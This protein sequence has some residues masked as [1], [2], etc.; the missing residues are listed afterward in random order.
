MANFKPTGRGLEKNFRYPTFIASKF[1]IVVMKTLTL[2]TFSSLLPPASRTAE[3]FARAC[4]W[5]GVT[6]GCWSRENNEG[7]KG[8]IE[9]QPKFDDNDEGGLAE[10]KKVKP[11]VLSVML[12]STRLNVAVSIPIFPEQYIIPPYL[13]CHHTL[14]LAFLYLPISGDT[15]ECT[16]EQLD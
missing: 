8:W 9:M 14:R 7:T 16:N 15:Y 4:S 2:T 10:R 11:T 13:I 12:P 3:R 1:V 5:C 6:A